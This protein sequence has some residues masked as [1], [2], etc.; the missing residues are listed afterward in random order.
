MNSISTKITTLFGAAVS[1]LFLAACGGDSGN[2][3]SSETAKAICIEN[4]FERNKTIVTI[5]DE[6]SVNVNDILNASIDG[7]NLGSC[8]RNDAISNSD[9]TI[10]ELTAECG[11]IVPISSSSATNKSSS[12][13]AQE[14]EYCVFEADEICLQGAVTEC[15]QGGELSNTCP[16]EA[17]SSSA[18]S[19]S[20]SSA[21]GNSSSSASL[22]SSSKAGDYFTDLR[23]DQQYRIVKIGDQTWMRDNLNY[24]KDET[25][26]YCY[27]VDIKGPN[28]HR[29]SSTCD[30]GYGRNY[31]WNEAM[32]N[33][34][35][36]QGLC[37][38]GWRLPSATELTAIIDQP[39]FFILAGN[40]NLNEF[41]PPLGWKERENEGLYWS[42][43]SESFRLYINANPGSSNA[44][45]GASADDY[46]SVRCVKD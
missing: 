46:F 12:S 40:Y 41:Y 23:D 42:N 45:N 13:S 25:V 31:Q 15:P 36:E 35:S 39:N 8:S 4:A 7:I 5:L 21:A 26:G 38:D 10:L 11:E 29:D 17:S 34:T 20:S 27:G 24:S 22:S 9:K 32:N 43:T 18:V 1:A 3:S 30:N 2:S 28:P 33:S 16:Y 19:K 14:F 37:P 44:G 6:C